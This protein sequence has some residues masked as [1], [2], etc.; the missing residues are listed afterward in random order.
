VKLQAEARVERLQV[1]MLTQVV[2]LVVKTHD[3]ECPRFPQQRQSTEGE[4]DLTGV[5]KG[6]PGCTSS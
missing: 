2:I 5:S 6:I 3:A 1:R 4:S